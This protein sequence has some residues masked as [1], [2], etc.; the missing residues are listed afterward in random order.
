MGI[1]TVQDRVVQMAA[2]LVLEPIFETAFAPCSY[3]F[4]PRRGATMARERLRDL[5]ARGA[6]HVQDADSEPG[7]PVD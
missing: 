4:R 6:D 3:G 2:K 1:P 7:L 5:G